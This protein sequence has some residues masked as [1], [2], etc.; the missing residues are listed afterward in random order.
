MSLTWPSL[1]WAALFGHGL[2]RSVRPT[3][4][5]IA[6]FSLILPIG[7]AAFWLL[8]VPRR[9]AGSHRWSWVP[10]AVWL[11]ALWWSGA[12]WE[13]TREL[14]PF[15]FL[16]PLPLFVL[17]GALRAG[18]PGRMDAASIADPLLRA[19]VGVGGLISLVVAAAIS[20]G[21]GGSFHHYEVCPAAC[22]AWPSVAWAPW[23]TALEATIAVALAV[24]LWRLRARRPSMRAVLVPGWGLVVLA[25]SRALDDALTLAAAREVLDSARLTDPD[26]ARLE[27][28]AAS[29][30]SFVNLGLGLSLTL[31]S[32]SLA[33][34]PRA[35]P[36]ASL[37]WRIWGP[38]VSVALAS[39]ALLFA[40]VPLWWGVQR[41][42][43]SSPELHPLVRSRPGTSPRSLDA[44]L[45]ADGTLVTLGREDEV[46]GV[47]PDERATMHQLL[48]ALRGP[49][50]APV[51]S[52]GWRRYDL[53]AAP[54]ARQRWAFVEAASR[55]FSARS[56]S[57]L[58]EVGS[59][60]PGPE[61]AGARYDRCAVGELQG[62]ALVLREVAAIT[63]GAWLDS[64][65]AIDEP[66]AVDLSRIRDSPAPH[67]SEPRHLDLVE[68]VGFPHSPWAWLLGLASGPLLVWLARRGS[69]AR[70][71]RFVSRELQ[72]D[73]LRR[74]HDGGGY[75][76][77]PT[78][79]R[80]FQFRR[81]SSRATLAVALAVLMGALIPVLLAHL[82]VLAR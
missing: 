16:I 78:P 60:E 52:I 50:R 28:L 15:P 68:R 20:L 42:T 9:G 40:P 38:V 70:L 71:V 3:L 29:S 5:L 12:T 44:E 7:F 23:G 13:A 30:E 56:L 59:C 22:G 36:I 26:P 47:L 74:E 43:A 75:R 4:A 49:H 39:T 62:E 17:G 24:M 25:A 45:L 32:S 61:L 79:V 21:V 14:A 48:A 33:S 72:L 76:D 63:V 27:Q 64:V 2:A 77:A 67:R 10:F 58:T 55:S 66:I 1:L 80:R 19:A 34:L 37:G 82:L 54:H 31:F 81:P 51:V 35:H 69:S 41:T 11:G 65:E 57:L 6:G 46:T 8:V 18:R 73:E 53:G